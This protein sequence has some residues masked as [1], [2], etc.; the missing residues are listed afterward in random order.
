MQYILKYSL[1]LVI[2]SL[3]ACPNTVLKD[4]PSAN[5]KELDI[6]A[7]EIPKSID[8]KDKVTTENQENNST[9][10]SSNNTLRN[11]VIA[12][13]GLATLGGLLYHHSGTCQ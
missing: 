11:T 8:L 12:G 1:F 13:V 5:R 3:T 9:Q 6:K 4:L 2:L 7:S 10:N